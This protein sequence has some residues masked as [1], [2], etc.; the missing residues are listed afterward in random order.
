MK[1]FIKTK[2]NSKGFGHLEVIV[3]VLFVIVFAGTATLIYK[4]DKNKSIT[5][6]VGYV[7]QD[8]TYL[9]SAPFNTPPKIGPPAGPIMKYYACLWTVGSVQMGFAYN[10]EGYVLASSPLNDMQSVGMTDLSSLTNLPIRWAVTMS[11]DNNLMYT[12][13][14]IHSRSLAPCLN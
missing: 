13:H 7:F 11:S 2:S 6:A 12:T 5:H 14:P 1:N 9:G 3:M 4:H 8:Y 10:V